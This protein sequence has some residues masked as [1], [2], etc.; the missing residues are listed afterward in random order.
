MNTQKFC[1]HCGAEIEFGSQFCDTCGQ[2]LQALGEKRTSPH[3]AQN[4]QARA[5]SG[6]YM[7]QRIAWALIFGLLLIPAVLYLI[8]RDVGELSSD[9]WLSLVVFILVT[10]VL[11]VI[12]L[13]KAGGTWQGELLEVIRRAKG[14]QFNFITD[15]GKSITIFGGSDLSDYFKPGDR[16]VKISGYDFPEKIDRDG[17]W[18]L[19]VAC[20]KIYSLHKKRCRF[21]R[22]PSIDPLNF[23]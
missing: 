20:G 15:Q 17:E 12:T 19:C 9:V 4:R 2:P 21:C 13:R 7:R 23:I 16:V 3:A 6:S 18:Q 8:W 14:V 11:V 22:Y 1:D 10:T 5:R